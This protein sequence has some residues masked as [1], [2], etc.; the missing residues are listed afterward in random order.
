MGNNKIMNNIVGLVILA[1]VG[2]M[3]IGG[4]YTIVQMPIVGGINLINRIRFNKK[5]RDGLKRGSI[6]EYE[7]KYYETVINIEEA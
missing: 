5:I 3:I 7:G 1:T 6:C 4:A 2:P